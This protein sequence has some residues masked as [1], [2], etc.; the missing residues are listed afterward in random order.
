MSP[1]TENGCDT[2]LVLGDLMKTAAFY[3]ILLEKGYIKKK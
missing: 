1:Y 3:N 2:L